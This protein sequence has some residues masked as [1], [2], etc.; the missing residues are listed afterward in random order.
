MYYFVKSTIIVMMNKN[1]N[2]FR[3]ETRLLHY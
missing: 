3:K 1:D 2:Q